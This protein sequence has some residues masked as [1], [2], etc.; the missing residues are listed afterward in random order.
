MVVVELT[1]DYLRCSL[2]NYIW[3]DYTIYLR[4]TERGALWEKCE[5]S[6]IKVIEHHE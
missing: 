5:L 3:T 6:I 4:L 1:S 2:S